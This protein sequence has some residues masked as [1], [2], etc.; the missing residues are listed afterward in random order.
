MNITMSELKGLCRFNKFVLCV[1]LQSWYTS[2]SAVDAPVNDMQLLQR[3]HRYDDQDLKAV[4]LKLMQRQSWHLS[5]EL[6][7]LSLF[8]DNLTDRQKANLVKNM[9]NERCPQLIKTL[10]LNVKY[11]KISRSFFTTTCLD[12]SF[13]HHPVTKWSKLSSCKIAKITAKNISCVNNCAER[14]VKLIE[15]FNSFTKDETQKQFLL[16]V[17]E[18][19]RHEFNTCNRKALFDI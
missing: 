14:G 3:L 19:H 2:R 4:G 8:S 5:P 17:V 15:D 1:Y 12:D 7:T 9:I 13:L 18:H 6:A 10:P 11:L 16:Q